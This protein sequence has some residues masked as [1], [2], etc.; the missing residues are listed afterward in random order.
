VQYFGI[1]FLVFPVFRLLSARA[2]GVVEAFVWML[3]FKQKHADTSSK[4]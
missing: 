3:A 1:F 4:T 2:D